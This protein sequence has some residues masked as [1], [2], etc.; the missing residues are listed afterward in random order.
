MKDGKIASSSDTAIVIWDNNT[1][2]SITTIKMHHSECNV[3]IIEINNFIV[4]AADNKLR[5]RDKSTYKCIK[6]IQKFKNYSSRKFSKLDDSTV[7]IG[8]GN[9]VIY[10]V[11]IKTYQVNRFQD[12]SLREICCLYVNGNG[13]VFIGNKKGEI[14]CYDSSSNK[15]IFKNK[16]H[17]EPILCLIGTEDNK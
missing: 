17:N 8:G 2:Q 15:I 6:T 1:Y 11:D 14:L 9:G 4:S 13:L 3:S 10:F 7:I 16:F 5:I 12:K